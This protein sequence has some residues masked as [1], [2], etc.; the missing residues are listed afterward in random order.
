VRDHPALQGFPHEGFCDLQ[1]YNLMERSAP[2][3]LD[4]LPNVTTII[5]GIRTKAGFL[6]K[7]KE[8]SKVGY[9]F[10]AK[11]G[12]GRLLVTTLRI[13]SQLDDAHPEAVFL[14]DRL[15]RYCDSRGFQPQADIP[16]DQLA[17]LISDYLR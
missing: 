4:A 10:E 3:P 11:V 6:S 17:Q 8:L 16:A 15:L 12:A 2:F 7:V 13:G 14:G 9:I 5:G 1:F